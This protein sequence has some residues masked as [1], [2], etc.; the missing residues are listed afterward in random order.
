MTCDSSLPVLAEKPVVSVGAAIVREGQV[1]LI[2]RGHPPLQG[3]W[4]LPGGRVELGE[5]LHE[6]LAREVLEETGLELTIGPIVEVL[7]RIDRTGDGRIAYHYVIIDFACRVVGGELACGSDAAGVR[8]TR[9]EE[10]PALGV[11]PEATAVLTRAVE[12]DQRWSPGEPHQVV[13]SYIN[14]NG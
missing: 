6:A 5:T 9:V 11:T 10:L 12:W 1:L 14:S 13:R 3:A 4:S 2:K 7:D 8:W